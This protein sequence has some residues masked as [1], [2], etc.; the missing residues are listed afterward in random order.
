VY[1]GGTITTFRPARRPRWTNSRLVAPMA[2]SAALPAMF[3]DLARNLGLK[4]STPITS[5]P[6]TTS[7][8]QT[9]AAAVFCRVAFLSNRAAWCFASA[10]PLDAFCPF[11]RLRLAILRW[12]FASS[13]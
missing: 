2:A 3:L 7:A 6:E 13:A 12:A 8:A 11:G 1:A 9:R 5:L 10:Y 4:S